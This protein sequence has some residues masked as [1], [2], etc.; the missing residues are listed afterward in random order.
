MTHAAL[1]RAGR[2][3]NFSLG[4]HCPD[5]L[6][7]EDAIKNGQTSFEHLMNIARGRLGKRGNAILERAVATGKNPVFDPETVSSVVAD[8]DMASIQRLA[9]QLAR[10]G[11]WKCPTLVVTDRIL[12]SAEQFKH[13]PWL[14]LIAPFNRCLWNSFGQFVPTLK[15]LADLRQQLRETYLQVSIQG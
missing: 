3:Q 10:Q 13:E 11:I 15:D 2:Q 6:S 14:P 9:E 12:C 1:G 8:L 4:G 7:F 5:S